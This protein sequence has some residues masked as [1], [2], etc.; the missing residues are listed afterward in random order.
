MPTSR[1]RWP[2]MRARPPAR[3]PS[4]G[5]GSLAKVQIAKAERSAPLREPAPHRRLLD[6][7]QARGP[8]EIANQTQVARQRDGARE[9]A[10]ALVAV[11]ARRRQLGGAE[12]GGRERRTRT[13][14]LA[15]AERLR[16][17]A[18]RLV[19]AAAAEEHVAE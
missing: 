9:V 6:G 4:D 13:D 2:S 19:E 12:G 16:V 17:G 14:R 3:A 1:G 18:L 15:E 5:R 11:A 7:P 10:L 8:V